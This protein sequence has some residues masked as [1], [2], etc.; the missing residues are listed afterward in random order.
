MVCAQLGMTT[1]DAQVSLVSLPTQ[2]QQRGSSVCE[3]DAVGNINIADS[4]LSPHLFLQCILFINYS[5]AFVHSLPPW[6]GI[7]LLLNVD[8]DHP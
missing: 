4:Y 6:V 1:D 2:R 7:S 5:W 3:C 8:C